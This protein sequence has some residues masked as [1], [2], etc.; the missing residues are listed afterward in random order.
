MPRSVSA[1]V[2]T[3]VCV[4]SAVGALARTPAQTP[5][6]VRVGGA[7]RAPEK[8]RNVPPVYPDAALA[9]RI[10]GVVILALTV[11]ANGSVEEASVL[12]SIPA[13]D[14][15]AIDAAT[16]W[17]YTPTLLNGVPVKVMHTVTVNFSLA[18]E[19]AARAA[20]TVGTPMAP[21][22]QRAT[23][24]TAAAGSTRPGVVAPPPN[25]AVADRN[26]GAVQPVAVRVGG[27]IR[28]PTKIADV[29]PVYPFTARQDGIS[30]IVILELL[31]GSSGFV[32]DARVIRS[33]PL[34]D[35]AALDAVRQWV[36][37]PTI[38]NGVAA[39]V[40]YTVTVNFSATQ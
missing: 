36:Y 12:R 34:L 14:Q 13:L 20:P 39:P 37:A 21:E 25:T 29:A 11:G 17:L 26:A 3:F 10:E 31:V 15:A 24:P 6:I 30:G 33:V 4:A 16:Q 27:F 38:V 1:V 19:A 9:A 2:V 32:E 18:S 7:I 23:A 40:Y 8:I 35:E 5:E 22:P 28:A